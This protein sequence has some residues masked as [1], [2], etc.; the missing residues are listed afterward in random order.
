MLVLATLLLAGFAEAR[1]SYQDSARLHDCGGRIELRES[2][3]NLHLQIENNR[4]CDEM[5]VRSSRYG[6]V[7][8]RY[9]LRRGDSNYTLSNRM[10]RELGR[11]GRIYIELNGTWGT[12]DGVHLN[13][14]TYRDDYR[15]DRWRDDRWRDDRWRD[16]G[17]NDR[18]DDD[19][20]RDRDRNRGGNSRQCGGHKAR[21]TT[22]YGYTNSCKCAYYRRGE[23]QRHASES[24]CRGRW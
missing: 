6:R 14:P 15:D 21:R 24:Y 4:R 9:N 20:W 2:R 5:I 16:D 22:G 11:D 12:S 3:Q 7:I 8:E 18:W 13:V 10:W 17:W 19:L 23:F 1:S